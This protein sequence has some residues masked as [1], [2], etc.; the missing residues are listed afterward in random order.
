MSRRFLAV[1]A[2]LV[3]GAVRTSPSASAAGSRAPAPVPVGPLVRYVDVSVATSWVAAGGNRPGIDDG[4]VSAPADPRSWVASMTQGQS[5]AL[6]PLLETQALYGTKVTVDEQLTVNGLLWDRAWVDGQPTPRD[7]HGYGAYPGWIPDRQLTDQAPP[8]S[9]TRARVTADVDAPGHSGTDGVTA[10]AYAT[11]ERAAARGDAGRVVEFSFETLLPVTAAPRGTD[12]VEVRDNHGRA[13]YLDRRDVGLTTPAAT[14][15]AVVA[16]ARQFL[17]LAYLW[18]GSSGF[19][20][21]CSG[22]THEMYASFGV[23]IPRDSDAQAAAGRPAH[24]GG[25]QTGSAVGTWITTMAGLRPGDLVFFADATRR[26]HH[27]GIYSGVV[28][29]HPMMINSPRTGSSVEEVPIDSGTW[30][31]E[32]VGGGR[33]LTA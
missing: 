18:A 2:V 3:A 24:A 33:F 28:D 12:W 11:P 7:V 16:R 32:F 26:I 25:R 21:D 17:G 6:T 14:G 22:F 31:K 1:T 20:Y 4:A 15:A 29:G 5:L 19:G 27:V 13:L 9:A 23:R 10:W 30:R 8:T